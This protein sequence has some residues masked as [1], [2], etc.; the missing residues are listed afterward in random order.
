[1]SVHF[2]DNFAFGVATA[3]FQ[4]E[5]A[6]N[7]DGRVD[8]IWDV[9]CRQPGAIANGEDAT[10]ACD[11]YHRYPDDIA[12]MADLGVDTYRFSIAWPRVFNADGV[13]PAG[14]DFYSRLVDEICERG[15]TP[16]L[17]LY[18]WDLPAFLPG[19]WTNRD[20][21]YRFAEY[22]QVVHDRLS[23]RVRTWTTLNEPWCSAFLGYAAGHHAPGLTD[24]TSSIRAAHH[25]LLGHGLVVQALRE[26]DPGA[27]LGITMNFT[28]AMPATTE[29][30]DV[31]VARRIDGTANRFFAD[32]VFKGRYPA[33]VVADLAEVWPED[34]V[35]DGDLDVISSPIDVL[36]VN[37]Y[38]TNVF[39]AGEP[40]EATPSPHI[41]A[42]DAVHVLRDLPL[43]A[44]GWEVE[45]S[46]LHRLLKRLQDDYTG[47]AGAAL[48]ITENGAAFADT[49]D[50]DGFVDDTSD[51]WE[52]LRR[53]LLAAHRAI[54]EGVN[55]QGYLVWSLI[56]NFEWAFGYEKRFG[57]VRIDE[58][59]NRVPK[60]SGRQFAQ[61][62][63][64][65][66]VPAAA[67]ASSAG[68]VS[69]VAGVDSVIGQAGDSPT[70][71]QG[72]TATAAASPVSPPPDSPGGD[73]DMVRPAAPD[74]LRVEQP[75]VLPAPPSTPVSGGSA[76]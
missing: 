45:P 49:P 27:R 60:A 36:G 26:A 4:I 32:A 62:A 58:N 42:P 18:H 28:P 43:T 76:S 2:P 55:L 39:A 68:V 23:D 63:A 3:A 64:T 51:R 1:M 52:Y 24:R 56:D 9:F 71:A 46:G 34:L 67:S 70:S 47:P 5:G 74:V 17:T 75:P 44:M 22:A 40:S 10:V 57:L 33:D 66:E 50:E 30:Q 20:T 53:H 35:Y 13:N 6:V 31:D 8:S 48:V 16:W 54:E 38:T 69:S 29:S 11:H 12:L 59:L 61:V 19:G 25:L 15:I 41:T 21:A 37:Y 7:E 65:H 14:L 72:S 73:Q